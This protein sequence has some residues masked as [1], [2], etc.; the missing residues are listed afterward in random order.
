[1]QDL[2]LAGRREAAA[3]RVP[4]ELGLKT[5]L[6][7]PPAAIAERVRAYAAA[8][9]TTLQAKLAGGT[10]ERLDTLA[11][12]LDVVAEVNSAP[13]APRPG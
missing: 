9:I 7:G 8:G 12:L 11:Q 5:N 2:W 3:A 13:S 4:L 6:L 10:T 1:M